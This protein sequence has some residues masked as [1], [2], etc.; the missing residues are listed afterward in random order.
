MTNKKFAEKNAGRI[1]LYRGYR[2]KIVG[3]LEDT[4]NIIIVTKCPFGWDQSLL[5]KW[6]VIL[7]GMRSLDKFMCVHMGELTIQPDE[8]RIFAETNAGKMCECKGKKYRVVGYSNYF[9]NFVIVTNR[10]GWDKSELHKSDAILVEGKYRKLYYLH[11]HDL[12]TI[13]K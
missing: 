13:E 1:R 7:A 5:S 11:V 4:I 9:P 6:H 2:V 12:K 8:N 10:S 3:Y